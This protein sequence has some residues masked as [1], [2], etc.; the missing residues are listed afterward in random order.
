MVEPCCFHKIMENM[1]VT[2]IPRLCLQ[3]LF[4]DQMMRK[5]YLDGHQSSFTN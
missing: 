2:F 3:L 4:C 1:H 5:N